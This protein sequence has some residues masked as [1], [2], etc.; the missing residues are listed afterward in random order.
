MT[1]QSFASENTRKNIPWAE[2]AKIFHLEHLSQHRTVT[3]V[4]ENKKSPEEVSDAELVAQLNRVYNPDVGEAVISVA[5]RDPISVGTEQ[6]RLP[7]YPDEYEIGSGWLYVRKTNGKVE[8]VVRLCNFF[9]QVKA[10]IVCDDGVKEDRMFRIGILARDGSEICCTD[11]HASDLEDKKWIMELPS[12][13][14]YTAVGSVE[15]HIAVAVRST[16]PQAEQKHIYA[17]T[18]FKKI[19]GKVQY[20]LPSH[21]L[22]D[23]ELEGSK[24]GGGYPSADTT[25]QVRIP[26]PGHPGQNGSK[27]LDI[28]QNPLHRLYLSVLRPQQGFRNDPNEIP[29]PPPAAHLRFA[30]VCPVGLRF[31]T[32]EGLFKGEVVIIRADV[33]AEFLDRRLEQ[34]GVIRRMEDPFEDRDLRIPAG[35]AKK[36]DHEGERPFDTF[37]PV[38]VQD[39]HPDHIV[40]QTH[41]AGVDPFLQEFRGG[42]FAAPGIAAEKDEFCHDALLG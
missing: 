13:C 12:V 28:P 29:V 22:Y 10:E 24:K 38:G 21:P 15:K 27:L 16:G 36:L 9:P 40:G 3:P 35:V 11:V 2:V 34:R 32:A 7:D 4:A 17:Y 39:L 31:M 42:G 25:P 18:G 30:E 5:E 8:Q 14:Q 41:G 23:V 20:L 26:C 1:N 6:N 37:P 33:F 19:D